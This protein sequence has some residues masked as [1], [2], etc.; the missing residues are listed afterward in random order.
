[1]SKQLIDYHIG[2]L[3]DKNPSVRLKSIKELVLL[4]ASEALETL[5]DVFQH[6][7]NEDVRKAA[8]EAG[9]IIFRK[10]HGTKE[11]QQKEIKQM[12]S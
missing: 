3:K 10:E 1:M 2:R 9:R 11:L 8:Q 4:E 5:R 6:D 12:K 7:A